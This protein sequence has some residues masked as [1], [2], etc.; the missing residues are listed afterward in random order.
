MTGGRQ[1]AR[2]AGDVLQGTLYRIHG[3][4]QPK[5]SATTYRRAASACSMRT[6][7]I[8]TIV[9]VS[10]QS[11]GAA[12][13]R[14]A[15][16]ATPIAPRTT[17]PVR[18]YSAE[19]TRPVPIAPASLTHR[20]CPGGW[21][22]CPTTVVGRWRVAAMSARV[23]PFGGRRQ[24]LAQLRSALRRERSCLQNRV[25]QRSLYGGVRIC[26]NPVARVPSNR[27]DAVL[28]CAARAGRRMG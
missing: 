8:S 24:G 6:R 23:P 12:G 15:Q 1:S 17:A 5:P 18:R 9:S 4:S 26:R 25:Y 7:S 22:T 3:T 14:L 19:L 10:H 21:P 11:R 16:Q 2:R 13:I 28:Q 20:M 27:Y